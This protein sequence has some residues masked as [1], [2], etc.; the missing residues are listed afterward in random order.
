MSKQQ[1]NPK[2]KRKT[3]KASKMIEGRLNAEM[4]IREFERDEATAS[5]RKGTFN[6]EGAFDEALG[7][8]LDVKPT[9]EPQE[10]EKP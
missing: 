10:T 7:T 8:I 2:R 4:M 9:Q 1:R 3:R 5:H 6:I